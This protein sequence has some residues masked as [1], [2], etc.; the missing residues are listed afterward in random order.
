MELNELRRQIDGI[1]QELV[2]LFLRRM[3]VSAQVA[4]YKREH[5]LP[6]LDAAREAALLDRISAMAGDE[7]EAPAR[8]LY[9]TILEQ[10]RAYQE[11]ALGAEVTE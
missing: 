4:E 9:A 1:D 6:V 2:A 3:H 11:K 5:D 7:L 8:A 10:S